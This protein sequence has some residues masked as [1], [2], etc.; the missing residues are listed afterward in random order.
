MKSLEIKTLENNEIIKLENQ[1]NLEKRNLQSSSDK[2]K[3]FEIKLM[4][5]IS[6]ELKKIDDDLY[7]KFN[8]LENIN[9]KTETNQKK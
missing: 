4:N 3:N 7:R 8:S 5:E 9:L 1:I 6:E 2:F